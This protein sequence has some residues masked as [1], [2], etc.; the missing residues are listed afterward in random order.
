MISG[1]SMFICT[2]GVLKPIWLHHTLRVGEGG[3]VLKL[4][5]NQSCI[6]LSE[7]IHGGVRGHREM[8]IYAQDRTGDLIRTGSQ[9]NINNLRRKEHELTHNSSIHIPIFPDYGYVAYRFYV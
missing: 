4:K 5:D 7:L 6:F 1:L 9:T 3:S 2:W 8:P